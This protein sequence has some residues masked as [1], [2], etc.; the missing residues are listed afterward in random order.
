MIYEISGV[1]FGVFFMCFFFLLRNIFE[2]FAQ[3]VKCHSLSYLWFTN[4]LSESLFIM[5]SKTYEVLFMPEQEKSPIQL[6]ICQ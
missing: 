6:Y 4:E 1:L 3:K 5:L 2:S